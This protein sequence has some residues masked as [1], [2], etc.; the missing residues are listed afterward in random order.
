MGCR[1]ADFFP[2]VLDV[3][4][5]IDVEKRVE[6]PRGIEVAKIAYERFMTGSVGR[7]P[8][9]DALNKTA[10]GLQAHPAVEG[11]VRKQPGVCANASAHFE[12]VAFNVGPQML[13]E[14]R[15]PIVSLFRV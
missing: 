15:L 11:G 3:L 6:Q 1:E 7:K 5:H 2:V 9:F 12:H 13:T 14:V 10:L 8:G 4:E